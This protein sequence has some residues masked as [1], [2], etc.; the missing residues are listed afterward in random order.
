VLPRTKVAGVCD[1]AIVRFGDRTVVVSVLPLLPLFA[2]ASL[3]PETFAVFEML[4]VPTGALVPTLTLKV[5]TLEPLVAMAVELVQVITLLAALQLQF[6]EFAPPSVNAPLATVKP[7]G[8]VSVTVIVPDV[9]AVPLFP[10]V[11]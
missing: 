5:K 7:V 11:T 3:P 9:A 10:T 4:S 6:A 2:V 1:F 8:N